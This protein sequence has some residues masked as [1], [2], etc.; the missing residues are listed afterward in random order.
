MLMFLI[1]YSGYR[2]GMVGIENRLYLHCG[3]F[4]FLLRPFVENN[5][6]VE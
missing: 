5:A 1:L 4:F 6:N 2:K 3:G